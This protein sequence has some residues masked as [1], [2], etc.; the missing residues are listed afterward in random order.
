MIILRQRAFAETQEKQGM[1]TGKKVALGT[2]GTLG[3]AGLA[4]AGARRG[5]F[6]NTLKQASNQAYGNFGKFIANKTKGKYGVGMAKDA[7]N[8]MGVNLYPET[9][10]ARLLS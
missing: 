4:F 1:S 7:A 2:L 6:G 10:P 5:K 8:K 3:A 9:N